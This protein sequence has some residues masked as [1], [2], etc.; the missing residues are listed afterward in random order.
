[1]FCAQHWVFC[2]TVRWRY[3]FLMT[4]VLFWGMHL[5]RPHAQLQ[6]AYK[7]IATQVNKPL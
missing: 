4:Y 6:A 7:A 5:G 3:W 1:M 2:C